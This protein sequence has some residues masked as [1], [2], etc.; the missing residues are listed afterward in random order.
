MRSS[1]KILSLVAASFI[2]LA[3]FAL[4]MILTSHYII[5][6]ILWLVIGIYSARTI[7]DTYQTHV[8]ELLIIYIGGPFGWLFIFF[9]SKLEPK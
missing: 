4:L 7:N 8:L 2:T 5:I 6:A 3:F 1:I 9:Y